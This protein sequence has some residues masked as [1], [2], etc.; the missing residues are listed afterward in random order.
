[1]AEGIGRNHAKNMSNQ[2]EFQ[3]FVSKKTDSD[4]K[5]LIIVYRDRFERLLAY[6]K[7]LRDQLILELPT[8]QAFRSG[9]VA[10]LRVEDVDLENGDIEVLDSKKYRYFTMPLNRTVAMHLSQYFQETNKKGR[11]FVIDP[12]PDAPRRGRKPGSKTRGEGL[13]ES[14]ISYIWKKYCQLVGLPQPLTPREGRAYF[15]A[16]WHFVL[17]KSVY[18]LKV[19]MRH[20]L[21]ET[22]MLYLAR[23][24]DQED[25]KNEFLMGERDFVSEFECTRLSLCPN[26]IEGCHCKFFMAQTHVHSEVASALFKKRK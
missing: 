18:H 1:M 11:D 21:L 3:H 14:Q 25:F 22:T 4:H 23:I 15:A 26:F 2:M 8:L 16:K 17:K 13:S 6:P 12:L 20:D 7:P 19:A 5:G 24:V 9:E 10:H